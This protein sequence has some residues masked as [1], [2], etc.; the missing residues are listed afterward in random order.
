MKT[1][2]V[3]FLEDLIPCKE[4]TKVGSAERWKEVFGKF[5]ASFSL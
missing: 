1:T 5:F 4:V 2:M 3:S